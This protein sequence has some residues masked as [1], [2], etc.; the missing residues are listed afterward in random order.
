MNVRRFV[1]TGAP[2]SGKT[3]LLEALRAQGLSVVPEAATDVIAAQQAHG[4]D[5]PWERDDFVPRVVS[6]QRRRQVA[7]LPADVNVQVFDRSPICTLALTRFLRRPVPPLLAAEVDR[8]L[9]EHVYELRVLLVRPLGFVHA[10][11]ARRITYEESLVFERVHIAVY[12]EHGFTLVD[13]PPAE[14]SRRVTVV[15]RLFRAG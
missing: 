9:A 10:T 14:V 13:V 3:V 15:T 12:R 5:E 6:L 2:G 8:I 4:L 1:L 11:A 7:P